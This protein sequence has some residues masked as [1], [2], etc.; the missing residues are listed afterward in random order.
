MLETGT[1]KRE[2]YDETLVQ[3][4]LEEALVNEKEQGALHNLAAKVKTMDFSVLCGQQDHCV[5]DAGGTL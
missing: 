1:V 5:M 4:Y 2:E 3:I